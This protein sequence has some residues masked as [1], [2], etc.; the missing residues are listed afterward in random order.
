MTGG[1]HRVGAVWPPRGPFRLNGAAL[2]ASPGSTPAGAAKTCSSG[3][4]GQTVI[5]VDRTLTL[6][7]RLTGRLPTSR[8]PALTTGDRA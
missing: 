6:E 7:V 4:M 1:R 2:R 5:A 8:Y 3:K